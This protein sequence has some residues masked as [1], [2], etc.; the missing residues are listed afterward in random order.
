M[1]KTII[2]L[3]CLSL[4]PTISIV[5]ATSAPFVN[6][7]FDAG[8]T[9]WDTDGNTSLN[10]GQVE[11][12]T[13]GPGGAFS[14]ASLFQGDFFTGSN[15]IQLGA[16][17]NYLNFDV[18]YQDLGMGGSSGSLFTDNFQVSIFDEF[19]TGATDLLFISGFDF[20]V[21]SSL[22]SVS[23][24]VSSLAGFSVGLFFDVFNEDDGLNSLFTL[25]NISFSE[26]IPQTVATAPLPGAFILMS[27]GIFL[28]ASVSRFKQKYLK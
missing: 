3:F 11:L 7:N 20:S 12:S 16:T 28:F 1:K 23:L 19:G 5:Q 10:A 18:S 15:S 13:I 9:D 27:A 24:D 4:V 2:F 21:G 6:G 25:D 22:A 26:A 17:D 8:L 14:D